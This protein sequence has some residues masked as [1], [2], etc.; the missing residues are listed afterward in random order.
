MK[1]LLVLSI[2][3]DLTFTVFK[4]SLGKPPP[5]C[6]TEKEDEGER[7]FPPRPAFLQ[8]SLNVTFSLAHNFFYT[9]G[10]KNVIGKF[11]FLTFVSASHY[12]VPAI[13]LQ[14]QLHVLQ[15]P[16]VQ[17]AF[18]CH[19]GRD[20]PVVGCIKTELKRGRKNDTSNCLSLRRLLLRCISL[21][22]GV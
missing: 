2:S 20:T 11:V 9:H 13:N 22:V 18:L 8:T 15:K 4:S 6:N 7:R 14:S 10:N 16:P 17:N 3:F 12:S 21:C 19:C 1:Y 5:R